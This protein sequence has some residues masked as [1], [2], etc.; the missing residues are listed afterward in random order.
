VMFEVWGCVLESWRSNIDLNSARR[1]TAEAEFKWQK[2]CHDEIMLH[3]TKLGRRA[4]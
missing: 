2:S 4:G 3:L 1:D